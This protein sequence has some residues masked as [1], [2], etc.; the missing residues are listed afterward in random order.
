[1]GEGEVRLGGK[2]MVGNGE[3]DEGQV[4]KPQEFEIK[5]EG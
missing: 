4:K 2:E 3:R 5:G 1:M